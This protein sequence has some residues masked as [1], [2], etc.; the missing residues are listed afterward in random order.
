MSQNEQ[1]KFTVPFVDCDPSKNAVYVTSEGGARPYRGSIPVFPYEFSGWQ[2]E[3]LT[4]HD[5]CYIHA[6]LNP[7]VWFHVKGAD[8]IN[9]LNAISVSTFNNFPVGKGR[10]CIICRDDGKI[11]IDGIVVRRSEDEFITMCLPDWNEVNASMGNA[12]D[13]AS[14]N[15]ADEYF[16]YQLCGPRSL[17]VVEQATRQDLHDIKFMY[18]KDAKIAGKDVFILRTGMAGTLG[19]EVHGKADDALDVYKAIIE[20]GKPYGL[21]P[22]G[23]H[24]YR[25]THTEGS[26]PQ[27]SIHYSFGIDWIT[28]GIT[29]SCGPD[30]V[31]KFW[32][33]IDCGWEKMISFEHDFPGKAALQAELNGRHNTMVHLIWNTEDCVMVM[34]ASM[35][36]AKKCDLMEVCEDFNTVKSSALVHQDLIYDQDKVVG[37][38]SGRMFSPKN[39]EMMSLACIDQDYAVE[40]KTVEVLWGRPGTTQMRIKAVVRLAPYIKEC[41]N[42]SFDVEQIPHPI[43]D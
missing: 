18:A 6:G 37:C 13:I 17:E 23:R 27:A 36:P 14:R 41:R 32:S 33:P 25:N 7:F 19:Y 29:G 22:I 31:Y 20:A 2:D 11:L 24:A 15:M 39:M 5:S 1:L 34:A 42:D 16:F 26:I 10:H 40:G 9:M 8:F 38:A 30:S 35:D 43:F 28:S 21:K 4:W 3:E 12:F